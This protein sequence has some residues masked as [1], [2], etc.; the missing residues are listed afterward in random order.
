MIG[1]RIHLRVPH[2][3]IGVELRQPVRRALE[4]GDKVRQPL[5]GLLSADTARKLT[6][7]DCSETFIECG[8]KY[9]DGIVSSHV[10]SRYRKAHVL[11]AGLT[12]DV[13][14]EPHVVI[15][16]QIGAPL[17]PHGSIVVA[18]IWEKHVPRY[19]CVLV[20]MA[21][22]SIILLDDLLILTGKGE[23]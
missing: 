6:K 23:S 8:I 12:A 7:R 21:L 11:L 22:P 13:Q 9:S 1:L 19:F 16:R 20:D 4:V 17:G 2:L 15:R 3:A 18:I 14:F 5:S 10:P